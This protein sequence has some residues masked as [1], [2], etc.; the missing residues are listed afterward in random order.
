MFIDN[1]IFEGTKAVIVKEK[2]E[3]IEEQKIAELD[4]ELEKLFEEE[5]V[6]QAVLLRAPSALGELT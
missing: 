1:C 2:S 4:I 3:K 6:G 5:K